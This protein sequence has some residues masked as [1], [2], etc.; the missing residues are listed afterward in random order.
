MDLILF[1]VV[2]TMVA[3]V[4]LGGTRAGLADPTRVGLGRNSVAKVL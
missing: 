4:I 1:V 3:L 2:V